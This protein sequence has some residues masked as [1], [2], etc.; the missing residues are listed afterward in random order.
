MDLST[1]GLQRDV[2]N[3]SLRFAKGI[4]AEVVCHAGQRGSARRKA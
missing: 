1:H 4:G 2:L 3:S